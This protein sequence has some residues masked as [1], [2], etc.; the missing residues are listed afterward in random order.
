MLF[1]I[2]LRYFIFFQKI[3]YTLFTWWIR[4]IHYFYINIVRNIN[5]SFTIFFFISGFFITFM[6]I[7]RIF[8]IIRF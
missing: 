6:F 8:F 1:S 3:I 5:Y 2:M 4:S 7:N